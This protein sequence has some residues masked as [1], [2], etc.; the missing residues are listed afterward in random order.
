VLVIGTMNT[1]DQSLTHLDAALKRRFTMMEIYPESEKTLKHKKV[2]GIDL[3]ELLDAV[4]KKLVDNKLRDN[5]IGHAYFMDGDDPLVKISDLQ[6][7]FAYDIIPLLREYFYDDESKLKGIFGKD[8]W[9]DWFGENDD[10]NPKWQ[11]SGGEITFRDN[12]KKSFGV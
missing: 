5:Q 10:I 8:Q 9:Q 7:V 12:I 4:N 1:A 3:T 2:N 6:M 11:G